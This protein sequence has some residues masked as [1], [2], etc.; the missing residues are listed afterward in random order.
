MGRDGDNATMP[1]NGAHSSNA[2]EHRI[3]ASAS[4]MAAGS[5]GYGTTL[6]LDLTATIFNVSRGEPRILAAQDTG[7]EGTG[8]WKLPSLAY[9]SDGF[10]GLDDSLQDG[11][12]SLTGLQL[13]YTEQLG[14]ELLTKPNGFDGA[15]PMKRINVSYVALVSDKANAQFALRNGVAW[16]PLYDLLPWEDWRSGKPAVI[17]NTISPKLEEWAAADVASSDGRRNDIRVCFGTCQ[18][19][20]DEEKV[21]ERL[22][23]LLTSDTLPSIAA[24]HANS[25]RSPRKPE[26]AAQFDAQSLLGVARALGRLRGQIKMKPIVFEL[27]PDRFTLYEL[28]QTVEAILGPPLHKQNFRRLVEHMGLVEPTGEI[29][30]HTGGRPAQLFRFRPSVILEHVHPGMR[31]R[32]AR[33]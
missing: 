27:V 21:S 23:L 31:V 7:L 3:S 33:L 9:S 22:A 16:V 28:Q 1:K 5:E 15:N 2:T 10:D 29:K 12:R 30:S 4:S 13:G 14:S 20:W 11:M 8:R 19:G 24:E 17:A 6:G 32:G 25:R 26:L 18:G